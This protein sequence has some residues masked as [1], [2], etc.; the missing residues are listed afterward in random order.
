[1]KKLKADPAL[2]AKFKAEPVKVIE[3]LIGKDLPDEQIEKAAAL[4]KAKLASDD[5]AEKADDV[6]DAMKRSR[7]ALRLTRQAESG[8]RTMREPLSASREKGKAPVKQVL[9]CLG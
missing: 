6:K 2:L 3:K 5:I 7:Q 9:F 8:S 4:V 1:M